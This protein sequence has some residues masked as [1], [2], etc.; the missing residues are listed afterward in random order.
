ML[1]PKCKNEI[2]NDSFYCDQCGQEISY[3]QT[4]HKPGKGNRCTSC[5]GVMKRAS[6]FIGTPKGEKVEYGNSSNQSSH[7]TL[8]TSTE[9][10]P[11]HS[12]PFQ[13]DSKE[14][15]KQLIL[16]NNLLNIVIE[17]R[18]DAIIGRRQGIYNTVFSH[19]P[20]I[21]GT[22]GRI[23]FEEE[24]K[25]W[26][27]TDLNSS[28]GSKYNNVPLKPNVP[29]ILQHGSTIQVADILLTISIKP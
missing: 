15:C 24:L 13:L 7:D 9:E 1:C 20:Y 4:C 3:C 14:K 29:C 25:E 2:D 18:N 6:A 23:R 26:T 10:L 27:Y 22:H 17:G 21:S 12:S 11:T 16:S 5:G 8:S 19:F 28:N